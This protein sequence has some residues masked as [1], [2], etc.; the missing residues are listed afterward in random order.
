MIKPHGY[1][2]TV[3]GLL[4]IATLST[5]GKGDPKAEN[6]SAGDGA[7]TGTSNLDV[8]SSGSA[9]EGGPIKLS[10]ADLD[11][12]EKGIA[13]ETELVRAAAEKSAKATTPQERGEA[14]QAGFE[15]NTMAAAAPVTGL[16]AERYKLVRETLGRLLTTLDF[17]G[18]IDGPQSLDTSRA[19]AAMKA[20][21]ASDPY[22]A[23]DPASAA[24]LK[25]RLNRIVP[26]WVKY[27][28]LTAVG[29]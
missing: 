16:S 13:R 21:L 7:W 29:G 9:T 18:K 3:S 27:I 17:Q 10:T 1:G 20:R 28:N 25:A 23:L 26:L 6:T 22:S 11:G 2:L 24:E 15:M 5:C 12:F 19:D 14:I 4:L 8:A